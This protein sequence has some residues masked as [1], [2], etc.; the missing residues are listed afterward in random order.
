M[1][2]TCQPHKPVGHGKLARDGDKHGKYFASTS[3]SKATS[4]TCLQAV[5]IS[6]IRCKKEWLNVVVSFSKAFAIDGKTDTTS[7]K[8]EYS[9]VSCPNVENFA[10]IRKLMVRAYGLVFTCVGLGF[11]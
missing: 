8:C 7:L 2:V 6:S 5:S 4:S 11:G 1:Y 10:R 9:S 3:V